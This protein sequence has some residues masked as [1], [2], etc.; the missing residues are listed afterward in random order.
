MPIIAGVDE[1]GRGALAGPVVAAAVILCPGDAG[2]YADS[3]QL[4]AAKRR[5]LFQALRESG[6]WIGVGI[7]NHRHIDRVNILQATLLAMSKSV[8]R[9]GQTPDEVL[10]DGK[11]IPKQLR[12]PARA[13]VG[14]DDTVRCISAA[15]IV[16]KVVRDFL[17]E[18]Y[19]QRYPQYGFM[20]HKGYGTLAHRRIIATNHFS[21]I[22]RRTFMVKLEG[23]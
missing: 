6:A 15:S 18:R 23:L 5:A 11:Q 1:A 7:V 17:M 8:A 3:K 19:D 13:I 12:I 16:A 4:S 14:G 9:L 21:P 22:H 2:E 20:K 10:I